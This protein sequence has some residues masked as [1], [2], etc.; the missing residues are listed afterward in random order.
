MIH[1][2]LGVGIAVLH[3]SNIHTE[4][5]VIVFLIIAKN[6]LKKLSNG[7]NLRKRLYNIST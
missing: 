1:M 6:A 2:C 5:Q 3:L 7:L 4:I